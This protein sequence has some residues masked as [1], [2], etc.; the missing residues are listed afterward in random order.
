VGNEVKREGEEEEERLHDHTPR[1]SIID[2][3]KAKKATTIFWQRCKYTRGEKRA[4]N[5]NDI[6]C[7]IEYIWIKKT[8]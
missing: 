1:L 4:N 7:L 2:K 8:M 5:V 3:Q 6:A